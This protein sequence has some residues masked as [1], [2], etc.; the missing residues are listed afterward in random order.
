VCRLESRIISVVNRPLDLIVEV[1]RVKEAFG[2]ERR[3]SGV[4]FDAGN[5]AIT[6]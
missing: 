4:E 5:S 2:F 6:K 1:E 3:G